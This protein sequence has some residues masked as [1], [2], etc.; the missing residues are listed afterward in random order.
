M[1]DTS[2]AMRIGIAIA[3]GYG[4][5]SA[6]AAQTAPEDEPGET[7]LVTASP[8]GYT[9]SE[10]GLAKIPVPLRDLPQSIATVTAAV[11]RDQRA[12][13]VQDALKNV[14]GVSFA[15]GD[16][17]RDQVTIRGF[18]AIADQYVNGFRDDALYYRDLSNVERVEVVK[19]PAAVLFGR[20]SSGGLINRVLKRPDSNVTAAALS[21]GS[22]A[23]R[24][25]EWDVGRFDA[26]SGVGF[27]ITG[28][29]EDDDSFRDQQLLRRSAIAPSL[30]I[31]EGRA[32]TLMLE[33]D[34]LHD[35]R[36]MDLGI[37]ALGGRPIDVP[38]ST[39]YGA[40][41]ARDVDT[42]TSKVYSQTVELTHRLS[43]ALRFRNGFRHY[44]Y[45][46]WRNSTLPA[47]ID[48]VARTV[49]LQHGRLNRDEEGWSDQAELTWRGRLAGV[50]HV[51]LYGVELSRQTK[52]AD[53]FAQVKVAVTS[54]FKPV[55]PVLDPA[56]F[57][58]IATA[59]ASVF[60]TGGVYVQDFADFGHGIKAL[61]GVRRDR[62]RQ[63][64][65]QRLPVAARLVRT[66]IA[67]SPRAGI[68]LQPDA[69]QSYYLS[70]SRSF[71]PS[72]ETFALT[73]SNADIA[74]EQTSNKEVGGKYTLLGGALNV[75]AAG[76]LLRRTGIKGTDPLDPTR[77]VAAGTQ[78]TRGVELSAQMTLPAGF[79]A[80]AGYAYLDARITASS[81][82]DFVGKGATI[83]PRHAANG[84]LS[85]S[86]AGRFGLGGGINYVGDR[87]A[88]PL[89]TT[90]L[91][92]YVTVDGLLWVA[93]GP[94]RW[95]LNAYNLGNVHYT[96]AGHGT[97]A[98]LNMPGAPR[99]VLGT[100]RIAL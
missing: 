53:T 12:L 8:Q 93:T 22:Y 77:L 67:W 39:Y 75:Q 100:L 23:A 86:F 31:G 71:Q 87:W 16:G 9:A 96:V 78:R 64:T 59:T 48:P 21:A 97:S 45:R 43:E 42:T 52:R 35:H 3:V 5:V 26:R 85:K 47:A 92:H 41:N 13:S 95:Q 17:Q 60:D 25:A 50:D 88:D 44:D 14:P 6:A 63:A 40:A 7:I 61:V 80:V 1:I 98:L 69:T 70:W 91:P 18:S 90:V 19:G 10:T 54:L 27:R 94:L 72:A 51:L 56:R 76:F 65:D 82:P 46:L 24:R 89:N 11:L 84:F 4:A 57:T 28:A 32:T 79:Q 15:A 29:H 83:A 55:L 20:G 30:L 68:V 66:D 38:R 34:A 37:P 58:R 49:T 33:A 36:L 74:P 81:R 73:A 62:F 99:S 2:L